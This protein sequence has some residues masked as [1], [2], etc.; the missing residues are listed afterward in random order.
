MRFE[1]IEAETIGEFR[2]RMRAY[3]EHGFGYGPGPHP[4]PASAAARELFLDGLLEAACE[5]LG[6]ERVEL[7][8]HKPLDR[9]PPPLDRRPAF[10]LR[11]P[12]AGGGL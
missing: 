3:L 8:D 6:R 12:P 2:M 4:H 7:C 11:R 9:V 1:R 10:K 5:A